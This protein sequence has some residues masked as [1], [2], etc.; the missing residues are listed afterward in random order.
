[1]NLPAAY[2]VIWENMFGLTASKFCVM[3]QVLICRARW[4]NF[5]LT[6]N[7][8]VQRSIHSLEEV[9]TAPLQRPHPRWLNIFAQQVIQ[10]GRALHARACPTVACSEISGLQ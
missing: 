6:F 10:V 8:Y 1:M 9:C 4:Y 5:A 7:Q 2:L 3:L